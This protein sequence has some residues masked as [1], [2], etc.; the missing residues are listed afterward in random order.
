MSA[1]TSGYWVC[2]HES[3]WRFLRALSNYS[4]AFPF[5]AVTTRVRYV[6]YSRWGEDLER[7]AP[8]RINRGRE[9]KTVK[10]RVKV[11]NCS[12]RVHSSTRVRPIKDQTVRTTMFCRVSEHR[13]WYVRFSHRRVSR[14]CG[15]DSKTPRGVRRRRSFAAAFHTESAW[16][17]PRNAV[18][19][20]TSEIVQTSTTG[21]PV[22]SSS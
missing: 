13:V 15:S 16:S 4:R 17:S 14:V 12:T 2:I 19:R 10:Y 9:I 11:S 21:M 7:H 5:A 8:S 3:S 20:R 6:F 1:R 18:V 22:T